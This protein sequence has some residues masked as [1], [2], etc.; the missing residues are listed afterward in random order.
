MDSVP[1]VGE[2][3]NSVLRG[4]GYDDT[5]ITALRADGAV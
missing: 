2:H 1:A 5:A 4:L 3:T